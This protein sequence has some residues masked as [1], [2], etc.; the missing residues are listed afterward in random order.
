MCPQPPAR[1]P[2]GHEDDNRRIIHLAAGDTVPEVAFTGGEP[3]LLLDHLCELIELARRHLPETRAVVL[4]N[5]RS[6]SDFSVAKR[7]ALL[8]HPDLLF[9]VSLQADIPRLHDHI[10]GS[11]GALAEAVSG[12]HHLARLRQRTAVRIV[13]QKQN[14]E[15]LPGLAEY[16]YRNLPFVGHVAWMGLEVIGAARENLDHVWAEAHE[17]NPALLRAVRHLHRRGI[18]TSIY[19]LPLCLLPTELWPFARD[20][21]SDWKKNYLKACAECSVQEACC[22]VFGTSS[23]AMTGITPIRNG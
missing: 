9:E 15:R 7:L 6:L 4:T 22:G 5:A 12:L 17:L 21:I 23:K 11:K 8:G 3:T 14:I 19:N 18:P 16:I 1:D 20:S 13:L 10:M 2:I